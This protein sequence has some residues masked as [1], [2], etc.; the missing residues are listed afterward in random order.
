VELAENA[1]EPLRKVSSGTDRPDLGARASP[2]PLPALRE[3]R[4]VLKRAT[5]LCVDQCNYANYLSLRVM[6]DAKEISTEGL[7]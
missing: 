2:R 7:G 6:A 5:I 1:L 3:L 4:N